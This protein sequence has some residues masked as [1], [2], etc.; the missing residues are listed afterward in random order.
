MLTFTGLQDMESTKS[1]E[2]AA[3]TH[4][5]EAWTRKRRTVTVVLPAYN[6]AHRIGNLLHNID[7]AMRE[8]ALQ[9]R[10]VLVDDGSSDQTLNIVE[11]C[12]QRMPIHIERHQVNAGLGA[13]I[14]DGLFIAAKTSET[15]D[16]IV[17]MD[18]DDTHTPWL[19]LRMV[20]MLSEGYD[21]V[22]ASRYRPESRIIGVP[23]HRRFISRAGSLLF[24]LLFPLAG[25]RDYTCGYRAYRADV[26]QR[27]I[28][29]YGKGFLDQ[30]GF[31][32]MVDILLKLRTMH[33]IFGEVPFILRYDVKEGGTKMK[34]AKTV[35][36]TL[37][38]LLK[39]RMGV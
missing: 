10:V 24:Q 32:C 23:L 7:E 20:R 39:R 29:H 14:R 12:A 25:V 19:I 33:L 37:S 34:V 27:A 17:T 4:E 22:I 31:Q 30:D 38:L 8:A 35:I 1:P 6:E 26:I 15:R 13:T 2:T 28:A 11:T 5:A 18:A 21:V 16:I 36:S 3:A 9:Y